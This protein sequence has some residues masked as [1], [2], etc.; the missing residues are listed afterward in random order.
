MTKPKRENAFKSKFSFLTDE[1]PEPEAA[2]LEPVQ[3]E[4]SPEPEPVAPAPEIT[5]PTQSVPTTPPATATR[6][7]K[8]MGKRSN[9]DFEQV[10]VYIPKTTA[11]QVRQRLAGRK[12]LDMSDLVSELLNNWLSDESN[13]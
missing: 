10:G 5:P 3:E 9:P 1:T 7:R 8:G 2:E 6:R 12:D 13:K 11:L 4:R